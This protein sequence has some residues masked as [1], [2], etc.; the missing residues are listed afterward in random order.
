[1][2]I[3]LETALGSIRIALDAGRAPITVQNFLGYVDEGFYDGG[4]FH[5]TVT[6]ENNA[7][8]NLRAEKIGKGIDPGADR[9]ALPNDAIAIQVIQGGINPARS[10]DQRPPIA[11]ERTRDTGLR[12]LDGTISMARFTLDSAVSDFFICIND[13]PSLDFGGQRNPDGQGFAAFGQV[14]DGMDVVRAIQ[15]QPANGQSLEPPV[16]IIRATRA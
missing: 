5:R 14:V 1:V 3:V 9:A 15:R 8:T 11:L 16:A 10:E 12:H 6:A 13:Q 7:N 4:R 2:D